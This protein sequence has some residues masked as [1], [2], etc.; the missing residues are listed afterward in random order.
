MAD[1]KY[2]LIIVTICVMQVIA[3]NKIEP[4]QLI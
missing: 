4:D 3:L 1:V 2:T